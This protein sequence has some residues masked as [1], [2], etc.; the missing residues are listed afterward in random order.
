MRFPRPPS[1]LALALCCAL[2]AVARAGATEM[3]INGGFESG[4]TIP[5]TP[6]TQSVPPGSTALD[7]WSVVG[8]AITIVTDTYFQPQAGS[9]SLALSATG[10]GG[11]SQTFATSTGA[12]YRLRF[13]LSGEPFTTPVVKHLRV[14]AGSVVHDYVFDTTPAWHWDMNWT[15]YMLDFTGTGPTTTVTFT[16]QDASSSGPAVESAVVEAQTVGVAPGAYALA[17]APMAPDP[18]RGAGR[19]AF[20]LPRAE[21]VRLS[22]VDVLGREVSVLADGALPAGPHDLAFM[23]QRTPA[24]SGLY[25]LVLRSDDGTLVRRFSLIR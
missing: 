13:W 3:L 24:R 15:P 4:P 11:I 12:P 17:L 25:F 16:S 18:L 10:P 20:T 14:Q 9:R 21:S 23:P 1:A 19:V 6:G 7:G 22:I 5:A 2:V 8:G